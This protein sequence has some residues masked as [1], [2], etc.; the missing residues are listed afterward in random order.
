MQVLTN[1]ENILKEHARRKAEKELQAE[2]AELRQIK[3]YDWQTKKGY[4][5]YRSAKPAVVENCPF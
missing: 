2:K 3:V 4:F 1:R 5:I